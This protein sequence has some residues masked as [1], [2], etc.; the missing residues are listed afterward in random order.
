VIQLLKTG[1]SVHRNQ[2]RTAGSPERQ[3][4]KNPLLIVLAAQSLFMP[5]I[6]SGAAQVQ[7]AQFWLTQPPACQTALGQPPAPVTAFRLTD[8]GGYFWFAVSGATAGGVASTEYY[9]P[10][11]SFYAPTSGA[12]QPV[13]TGGTICFTDPLFQVA[14]A[15][16]ATKPGTWTIRVKWN[17]TQ[18]YV[19]N[20]TIGVSL[21][22]R[23]V[24]VSPCRV[25]DTRVGEGK[26][27]AFGPPSLAAGATRQIPVPASGCDIPTTAK[28]YSLN[29]TVVPKGPLQFLTTWPTNVARP[30]VS[31]LNSFHGGIVS[32]AAIVP[33]G[34]DGSIQV[35]V[36]DATDVIIDVNGYFADITGANAFDFYTLSPC[37]AVDTRAGQGIGGLF[38]PPTMFGGASR[39]F[40]LLA[41]ICNVPASAKAYSL[42]ATVVPPGP[43]SY[44]TLY[45]AGKTLPPVST[46]NSFQG[47]IVANAALVPGG[48]G[49][50]ITAYVTN[51]TDLILDLNGYFAPP[52]A[53][54]LRFYPV[55]PC[56][57]A[58]TRAAQAPVM[59]GGSAR[60]FPVGGRC[61]VPAD[62]RAFAMNV[63]VVPRGPLS[64]LTLWPTGGVQPF[65]STL[66]SFKGRILANAALVPAGANGNVS[67]FVTDTTDVILDING[68]FAP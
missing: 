25:A 8:P 32:N 34:P 56:R 10:D 29:F 44:L 12:F 65:V 15:P 24:P 38:G 30:A 49:S 4:V 62:A 36:T 5:V 45:P 21:S 20:F 42:N 60:A 27:G 43:L 47:D 2:V 53:G 28:A 31:T 11:G 7:L 3:T 23:F 39:D 33:A 1:L 63:T 17:G 22:Y 58:D 66:N 59:T 18:I 48:N 26:T 14:G 64:Y 6:A 50:S 13:Q 35:Y 54:S 67:V 9:A 16:P 55:N 46:L 52:T 37:R 51:N 61:G 41:S 68:Y 40:P 57:I 19:H